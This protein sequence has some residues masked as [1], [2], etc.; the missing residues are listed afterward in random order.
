MLQSAQTLFEGDIA[1]KFF[2][3]LWRPM[4]VFDGASLFMTV[5]ESLCDPNTFDVNW[6][7]LQQ[8][9]TL[10]ELREKQLHIIREKASFWQPRAISI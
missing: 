2:L 5:S 4:L 10:Y 8:T 6:H 9:L 7:Y 3:P 1:T